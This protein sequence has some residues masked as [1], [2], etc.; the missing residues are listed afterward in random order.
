MKTPFSGG[1]P[2]YPT[3]YVKAMILQMGRTPNL[4]Y[5]LSVWAPPGSRR[6][7]HRMRVGEAAGF[8][9][10]HWIPEHL[11]A[12]VLAEPGEHRIHG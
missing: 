7:A 12:A 11:I 5:G 8:S 4:P 3:G 9:F 2:H 6:G 1:Q 10:A